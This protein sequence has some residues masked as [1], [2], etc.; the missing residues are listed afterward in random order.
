M[1]SRAACDVKLIVP[2]SP[3][4]VRR[5]VGSILHLYRPLGRM[6]HDVRTAA[7]DAIRIPSGSCNRRFHRLDGSQGPRTYVADSLGGWPWQTTAE[8]GRGG[9]RRRCKTLKRRPSIYLSTSYSLW[10][11]SRNLTLDSMVN[12]LFSS[13][14]GHQCFFGECS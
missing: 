2:S 11:A 6:T 7:T 9:R 4:E 5:K 10:H 14:H 8:D 13:A 12:V 3:T 1:A